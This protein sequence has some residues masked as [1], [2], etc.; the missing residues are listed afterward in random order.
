MEDVKEEKENQNVQDTIKNNNDNNNENCTHCDS[1]VT[2]ND[3]SNTNN[4]STDTPIS[5]QDKQNANEN[6]QAKDDKP[7]ND[8]ITKQLEV[9]KKENADLKDQL[10]RKAADFDNYR[11]RMIKEKQETYDFANAA[12]LTDLL[13]SLDNFDRTV[14]AAK[15]IPEAKVIVDGVNMVSKTL[16]S[17]L[18][19]KYN[20]SSFAKAGDEFDPSLHEALRSETGD[21]KVA[22]IKEVYLKGY[23]LRDRVIR[24]AKVAVVTP[25]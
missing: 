16:V 20:L 9:L 25:K 22:T 14:I 3:N 7:G 18:E 5:E 13:E 23:K 19:N 24:H 8:D 2:N 4:C 17:M 11:K 21:T 10:L 1:Q 15:D 12:L 6:T